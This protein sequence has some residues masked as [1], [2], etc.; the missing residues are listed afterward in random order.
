MQ[1][2]M[3][4]LDQNP[5][6]RGLR[7]DGDGLFFA[8]DA[9]LR[10]DGEGNFEARPDI[11]LR[12]SLNHTG[13]NE[14]RLESHIRSVKLIAAAL[15]KGDMGRAMMTAVLM[16]MGIPDPGSVVPPS[17]GGL[18]KAGY[19]PDEQRDERGR[20][21]NGG[22]GSTPKTAPATAHRDPRVQ[23]ASDGRSDAPND[24][25]AEAATRAAA[26][27]R[28][29][30]N[31]QS[32]SKPTES[33]EN[34]WEGLG[35]RLSHGVKSA[36]VRIGQAEAEQSYN[37]L[38]VTA[39][40]ANAIAHAAKAYAEYRDRILL[41]DKGHPIQIPNYTPMVGSGVAPFFDPGPGLF[42]APLT[43]PARNADWIDPLFNL[44]SFFAA[45]AGPMLRL[46]G[47]A[48]EALGEIAASLAESDTLIGNSGFRNINEF[49]DAVTVKYQDLYDQGYA[50]ATDRAKQGLIANNPLTIG[51]ETDLFARYALRDWLT[52]AEGIE[53][54]PG[55]IIQV[56]R[57]LYDP[58]GSGNYRV[59][60]VHIPDAQTILDGSTQFKTGATTQIA[61]YKLFSSGA[62]VTIIRPSAAAHRFL[63]GSYGIVR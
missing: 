27:A 58:L 17:G 12:K 60:D 11:E 45:G 26:A 59:P 42:D 41:D 10:Q 22:V 47:P 48:A 21:T 32:R 50:L 33:V 49:A 38:A 54:A 5:H 46:A 34:L 44:G 8:G 23:L 4:K 15:N 63:S 6:G 31:T 14:A 29:P 13:S 37:N 9:L 55:Q 19:N 2:R 52:N 35:S 56:N 24:A 39:D 43:R 25:V 51:R 7:C 30:V 20:W 61:D 1:P 3:F 16:L 18:A 40:Q 62:N 57:R 36:L 53:E 28:N